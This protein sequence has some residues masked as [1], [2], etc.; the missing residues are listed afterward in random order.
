MV[1][2]ESMTVVINLMDDRKKV[3]YLAPDEAVVA[4]YEEFEHGVSVSA[5]H[6]N[7]YRHPEFGEYRSGFAC[8]D[9]VTLKDPTGYPEHSVS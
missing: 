5:E 9:R 2:R 4:A 3:Y 8:G 6:I 7:P 1:E